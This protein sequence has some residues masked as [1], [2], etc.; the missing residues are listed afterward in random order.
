MP[1]LSMLPSDKSTKL[2]LLQLTMRV[3]PS[4]AH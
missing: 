1:W 2:V 4:T 3:L